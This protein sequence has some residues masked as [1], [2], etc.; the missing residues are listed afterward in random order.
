[1]K[2]PTFA[3]IGLALASAGAGAQSPQFPPDQVARARSCSR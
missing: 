1:M 3:V 2:A